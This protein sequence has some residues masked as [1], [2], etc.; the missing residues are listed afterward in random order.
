MDFVNNFIG[1]PNT[2]KTHTSLFRLWIEPYLRNPSKASEETLKSLVIFWRNE[3]LKPRTIKAL[4]SLAVRYIQ[5]SGG[6]SLSGVNLSKVVLQAQQSEPIKALNKEEIIR[7]LAICRGKDP[8]LYLPVIIALNTGMRRGE[9]FGLEWDDVDLLKG[10][11]T[12]R[13]SYDGPTKNGKSRIIPISPDLSRI[14]LEINFKNAD[15]YI[16]NEKIVRKFNPNPKLQ[17]MCKEA[18]IPVIHFHSLR[19]TFATLALE[20]GQSPKL[21]SETLGH[22]NVSTTLDLYWNSTREKIDLGFLPTIEK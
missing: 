13:R 15:N 11:I 5:W 2:I 19:H 12:V 9:V 16:G 20:S 3:G 14:L 4:I 10:T 21:V 7:L 17:A 1:R 22:S 6:P 8:S 18:E